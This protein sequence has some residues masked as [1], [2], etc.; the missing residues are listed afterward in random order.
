MHHMFSRNNCHKLMVNI[1]H[2][3][4]LTVSLSSCVCILSEIQC[5]DFIVVDAY[6][7]TY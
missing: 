5:P 2:V 1:E 3:A 6:L 7:L 4:L